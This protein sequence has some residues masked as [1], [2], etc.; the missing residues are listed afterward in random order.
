MGCGGCG[1]ETIITN[2]Q[3]SARDPSTHGTQK[4]EQLI[5]NQVAPGNIVIK[6]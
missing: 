6:Q 3:P 4:Q 5:C 2:L 1:T